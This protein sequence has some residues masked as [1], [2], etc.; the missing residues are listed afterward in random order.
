MGMVTAIALFWSNKPNPAIR[1]G[2]KDKMAAT[3]MDLAARRQWTPASI[4]P[5]DASGSSTTH[6]SSSPSVPSPILWARPSRTCLPH[7]TRRGRRV[8]AQTGSAQKLG[9]EGH[10]VTRVVKG[11]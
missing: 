5:T 1:A 4:S 8:I 6:G 11:G 2:E 3:S 10:H 7:S 9:K